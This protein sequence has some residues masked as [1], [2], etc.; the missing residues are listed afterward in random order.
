MSTPAIDVLGI[1]IVTV[2]DLIYVDQYPPSDSKVAVR[3]ELRVGGGLIGTS[4]SA[5]ARMGARATYFGVLGDDTHSLFTEQEFERY[6]V[7]CSRVLH[8][9]GARP[10]HATIV[11]DQSNGQRTIFHA[12]QASFIPRPEEISEALVAS[13][14]VLMVD[15]STAAS[16]LRAVALAHA[17][18]IPVVAD[19]ERE[20]A[21]EFPALFAAIDHLIIGA[22]FG[23]Q[24]TGETQP[25]QMVRALARS[26]RAC[27]V[28]TGGA[29]GCWYSEQDGAVVH[30]PALQVQSVDTTGCGDVFHGAY[31]AFLA[32]GCTVERAIQLATVAGG[33]KATR[34]GG[35]SGIP[36]RAE[37][38][39]Q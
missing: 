32:E 23:A 37:V 36:E 14:R 26:E 19:F 11:V 27:T 39:G 31:A 20:D 7:D 15:H 30:V 2:D 13:C 29:Q 4:L 21:A 1:G 17:H 10:M 35:R 12:T 34:A 8:R 16:G 33:I 5:A 25:E 18:A 28:I 24:V 3:K 6:G 38:L 9:L 22:S